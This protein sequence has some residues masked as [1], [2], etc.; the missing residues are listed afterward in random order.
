MFYAQVKD[1][2]VVQVLV[3]NDAWTEKETQEFLDTVNSVDTWVKASKDGN[4]NK[5][6]AGI[7]DEYHP[8]LEAFISK[9][10]ASWVIDTKRKMYLPPWPAPISIP[11]GY[12]YVWYEV[13]KEWTL[14]K[15]GVTK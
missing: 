12:I 13:T 7:G 3:I 6:Y 11:I 9:P 14:R 4:V 10:H 15:L 5:K 1:G 2:K 8:D